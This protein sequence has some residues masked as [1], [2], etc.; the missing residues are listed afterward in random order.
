MTI[1]YYY[2][3]WDDAQTRVQIEEVADGC[4]SSEINEALSAY[5]ALKG[6]SVHE[7]AIEEITSEQLM[8]ESIYDMLNHGGKLIREQND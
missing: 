4:D 3:T 7:W 5:L 1:A 8:N 2:N 6:I